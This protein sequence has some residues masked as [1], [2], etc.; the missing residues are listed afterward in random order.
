M[1]LVRADALFSASHQINSLKPKTKR[2]MAG[3]ETRPDRSTERLAA[4]IALVDANPGALAMKLPDPLY[5][6]AVRAHGPVRPEA[7]FDVGIGGV[8]I[9]EVLL[10]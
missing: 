3:L 1:K 8:F 2:D 6:D 4:L 9:V 5:A 10:M 7:A